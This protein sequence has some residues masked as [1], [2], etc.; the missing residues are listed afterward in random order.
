MKKRSKKLMAW[1]L[2]FV[3]CLQS[4]SFTALGAPNF[5]TT[6]Y[7]LESDSYTDGY[8]VTSGGVL[9]FAP[10]LTVNHEVTLQSG[11][12]TGTGKLI[13]PAT[14]TMN[15]GIIIPSGYF[16]NQIDNSGTI[17]YELE[18]T[19]GTIYNRGKISSLTLLG[20][21]M[22]HSED[23]ASYGMLDVSSAGSGALMTSG[24]MSADV[25][26]MDGYGFSEIDSSPTTIRVNDQ[27]M[28]VG[29]EALSDK[30][31]IQLNSKTETTIATE[32]QS[33][34]SVSFD[35]IK[36]PL[37]ALS[38]AEKS[39]NEIYAVSGDKSA[40]SYGDL[41]VGYQTTKSD[42]VKITNSGLADVQM[43]LVPSGAW[44]NMISVTSGGAKVSY[45]SPI[46]LPKG[47]A[48]TL[49]MGLNK[50]VAAGTNTGTLSVQLY[51]SEGVCYDSVAIG[52]TVVV[53]KEPSISAPSDFYT[54]SGEKGENGYYTSDVTV[55][56]TT[57]YQ[58]AKSLEDDFADTIVYSS[59]AKSPGVYLSKKSTGQITEQAKLETIKI[60]KTKPEVNRT[61][62][63][64]YYADKLS[65]KVTD[66]NLST[67]KVNGEAETVED[68]KATFKLEGSDDEE[69][70]YVIRAED[71][72]GNVRKVTV[73]V[74]PEWMENGKV[75]DGKA[76]KLYKNKKYK[77]GDGNFK[78]S[79]DSTTYK[80]GK[81][82][83]VTQS[84]EYTLSNAN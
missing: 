83:Y 81:A 80:G 45:N 36:Y 54:L 69:K 77:F 35:G 21:S 49:N 68:G 58:I 22:L 84:G 67:V 3:L 5:I 15:A 4:G 32:G 1:I 38:I 9:R 66:D 8:V 73:Y 24:A 19:D 40:V 78:V 65:V 61:S 51:T 76:V 25:L 41:V 30:L 52:A 74:A 28:Y 27:F 2:F 18:L 82:F 48:V 72:A 31:S 37:P 10:G 70:K 75:P 47:N 79:G 55:T 56:P 17:N 64:I 57:G 60:D 20:S 6:D 26:I 46:S 50:G 53:K 12:S 34:L 42:A 62:G 16:N 63:E 39:L 23:G 59:T 14:A 43:R 71:K 33:G 44:S 7:T 13:I 29:T 11:D